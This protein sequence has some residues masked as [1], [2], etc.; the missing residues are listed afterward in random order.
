MTPPFA[1]VSQA[2]FAALA[3][4]TSIWLSLFVLPGAGVQGRPIPLL[5]AINEAADSVAAQFQAPARPTAPASRRPA[6]PTQVVARPAAPSRA[7][8]SPQGRPNRVH[9]AHATVT[10]KPPAPIQAAA[11]VP[12]VSPAVAHRPTGPPPGTANALGRAK[13]ATP[14]AGV[15]SRARGLGKALGHHRGARPGHAKGASAAQPVPPRSHGHGTGNGGGHGE[16]KR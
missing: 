14:R 7:A 5:P 11:L 6:S 4:A 1:Q 8:V 10:P 9:R 16:G 3:A 2:V 13:G 12:A 15:G